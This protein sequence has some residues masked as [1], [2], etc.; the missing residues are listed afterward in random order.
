MDM[1]EFA[2]PKE[3]LITYVL[4]R[5][6]DLELLHRCYD[7][8]SVTGFNRVGHILMGNARSFGFASLED[9][10]KQMNTLSQEELPKRGPQI[11]QQFSNWIESNRI[12]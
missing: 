9:I 11:L 4:R 12:E 7:E 5:K 6:E 10:A 2:L 3:M 1:D 8:K